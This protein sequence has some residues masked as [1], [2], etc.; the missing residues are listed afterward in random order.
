MT[1]RILVPA[2]PLLLAIIAPFV[3]SSYAVTMLNYVFINAIVVLGLV[4]LTG[5]LGL[6]SFGQAAFVG[7]GAYATA[8][9]TVTLGLSPWLSLVLCVLVCGAIALSVGAM[10][11]RMGGH[12]LAI[13][14]LAWGISF[15]YVFGNLRALGGFTGFGNIPAPSLGSWTLAGERSMY[16]LIVLMLVASIWACVNLLDSRVGRAMRSI[17]YGAA[18]PESFGVNVPRIKLTVFVLAA[19][20]A[21]ASGWLYAH[22]QGYINPSPFSVTVSI[23]YLFMAVIG[24]AAQIA[25][26]LLGAGV[27]TLVRDWLQDLMTAL[28]GQAGNFE[29]VVFG[30]LMLII[31]NRAKSGLWPFLNSMLPK[32]SRCALPLAGPLPK[33]K[34]PSSTGN[35]LE[36]RAARKNFGGLVAVNAMSFEIEAGQILGLIGPNGAGKSTMFNLIS[37]LLS[38]SS[39]EVVFRGRRIDGMSSAAIAKLGIS[40]TF[41]HVKIVRSMTVLENVALGAWLRT[42]TGFVRSAL[43]LDRAAEKA[44]FAD[45]LYQL[46]R[47]G[48]GDMHGARSG[49]LALGKQRILE[50]ARA[51]ASDPVLLLLDEPA[52]GLR[53]LEK[54]ALADLLVNLRQQGLAILLVE[55]DMDFVMEVTDKL[56]VMN[57]G[58]KLAS[59]TPM[60]VQSNPKVLEAYLGSDE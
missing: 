47:V 38:L 52:A 15:Y 41:Q 26:A 57:F 25:G 22:L 21:A 8:W 20:L 12:Y 24:G 31:L 6:I 48:L 40:R 58:E 54:R 37:G 1:R 14:T 60:E 59:G 5:V 9:M 43:R 36:V 13:A 28:V 55:H 53:A 18:L 44:V 46:E 42:S 29:V 27:V 49:A 4:L 56:V 51:L 11:L 39:G 7:V 16:A 30:V 2:V 35:V 3:L 33:V 32:P 50:I 34:R 19:M 23:E 45:A 10:T 17:R